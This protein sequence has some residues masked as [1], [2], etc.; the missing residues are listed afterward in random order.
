MSAWMHPRLNNREFFLTWSGHMKRAKHLQGL[1][2]NVTL[3]KHPWFGYH[4]YWG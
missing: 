4:I 3:S 1:G 2:V